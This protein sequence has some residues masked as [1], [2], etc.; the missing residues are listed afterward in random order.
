MARGSRSSRR[1]VAY[2]GWVYPASPPAG[3]LH[4]LVQHAAVAPGGLRP[5]ERD[6]GELV[7]APGVARDGELAHADRQR[8]GGDLAEVDGGHRAP[9]ALGRVA[10]GGPVRVGEDPG[11]LLAADARH[12]VA[13]PA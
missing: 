8:R 11:E 3:V 1:S 4:R 5:V 2:P 13:E 10:R 9:D 6:V 7:E 12:V